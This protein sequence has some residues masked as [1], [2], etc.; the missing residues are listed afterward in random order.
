MVYWLTDLLSL[1]NRLQK[2]DFT[3]C[4]TKVPACDKLLLIIDVKEEAFLNDT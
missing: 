3:D 1:H 2:L 4:H